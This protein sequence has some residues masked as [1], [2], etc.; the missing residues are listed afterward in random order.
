MLKCEM[1]GKACT[2]R[3]EPILEE[4]GA[5]FIQPKH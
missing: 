2:T 3:K 4:R 1:V 5:D